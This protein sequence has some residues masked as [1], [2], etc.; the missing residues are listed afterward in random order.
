MAG[1]ATVAAIEFDGES[2]VNLNIIRLA[3]KKLRFFTEF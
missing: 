1:E 3:N 2:S